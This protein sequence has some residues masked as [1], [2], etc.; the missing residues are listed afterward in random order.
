MDAVHVR[1]N[2]HMYG[3]VGWGLGVGWG[4]CK[5]GTQYMQDIIFIC[6]VLAG[7]L[8]LV[9]WFCKRWTQYM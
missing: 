1:H 4:F 2:I 7:G 9:G 8:A 6:M 5:R 3:C